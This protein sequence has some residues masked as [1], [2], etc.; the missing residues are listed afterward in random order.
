MVTTSLN[1]SMMRLQRTPYDSTKV[2]P[3]VDLIPL[4]VSQVTFSQIYI[5]SNETRY[6]DWPSFVAWVKAQGGK[7]YNR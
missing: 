7:G 3:A 2:N 4:V 5:R 1:I 6:T